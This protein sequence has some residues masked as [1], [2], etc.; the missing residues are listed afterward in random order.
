[1]G[2]MTAMMPALVP[3]VATVWS[4]KMT[5]DPR[6]AAAAVDDRASFEAMIGPLVEPGY[7]LALTILRQREEAEDAVQEATIK[8]WRHLDQLR[9]GAPVRPWFLSIVANQARSVRRGRWFGVV[10]LADPERIGPG[11]EDAIAQHADIR[12]AMAKLDPDDRLALYLRYYMDLPLPEVA[13]VLGISESAAKARVHRAGKRM[14]PVLDLPE[15]L[16]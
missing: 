7:R 1:M 2:E 6:T 10:K 15:E 5:A 13:T 11:P 8:A 3:Q 14:K 4:P 12:R 16:R 9:P